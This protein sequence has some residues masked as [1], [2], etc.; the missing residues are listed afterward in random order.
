MFLHAGREYSHQGWRVVPSH[1]HK[2]KQTARREGYISGQ[3][4]YLKSLI[5]PT[6]HQ[7]ENHSDS[8][9]VCE[10]VTPIFFLLPSPHQAFLSLLPSSGNC[11]IIT[12]CSPVLTCWHQQEPSS[13]SGSSPPHRSQLP[14]AF[15]ESQEVMT[16][17]QLP[18]WCQ[19]L[20]LPGIK[21][22]PR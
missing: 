19:F 10:V 14:Q 22:F 6:S 4:N 7:K 11:Q 20:T 17:T 5:P 16:F 2:A 8:P 12:L 9:K 21:P 1:N 13:P 18:T 15:P 3:L